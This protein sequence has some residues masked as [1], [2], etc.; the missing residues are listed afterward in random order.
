LQFGHE[1]LQ[2]GGPIIL[3]TFLCSNQRAKR[4]P[5]FKKQE[6]YPQ[7]VNLPPILPK[8]KKKPYPIPFKEIKQA[9]RADKKLAEMNIEKA[10]EPPKNGL[11]V[12]DL[13]PVAYEIVDAWKV[14]IKGLAQLLH[15]VP[16][17]ACR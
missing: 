4:N 9:A 8:R 12:P 13:I 3:G 7:N 11:L 14:L 5:P 1:R 10:L 2:K 6:A 17:Y 15:V 16:V